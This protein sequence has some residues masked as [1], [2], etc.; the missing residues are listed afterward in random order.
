MMLERNALI[1]ESMAASGD[2]HHPNPDAPIPPPELIVNSITN[3]VA[4]GCFVG[5]EVDLSSGGASVVI[6]DDDD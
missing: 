2:N 6:I 5:L 1:I 3:T 4:E